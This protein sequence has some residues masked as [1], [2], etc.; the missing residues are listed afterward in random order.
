MGL[1][2][3]SLTSRLSNEGDRIEKPFLKWVAEKKV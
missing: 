2:H 3:V 1:L